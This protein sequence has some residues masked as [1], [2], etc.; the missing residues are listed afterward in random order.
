MEDSAMPRLYLQAVADTRPEL[1]NAAIR[2]SS[3][4]RSRWRA[5]APTTTRTA[6]SKRSATADNQPGLELGEH[7]FSELERVE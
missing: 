2:M 3:S 6:L 7:T 1:A 4:T 5:P